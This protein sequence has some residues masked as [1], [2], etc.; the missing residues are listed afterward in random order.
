M[1]THKDR[2]GHSSF[3]LELTRNAEAWRRLWLESKERS[4]VNTR[5]RH[6]R[7]AEIT[8]W[9]RRAGSY[10]RHAE[11]EKSRRRRDRVLAWLA[12][13][14]ALTPE[15]RVLDIGAGPGNYALPLAQRVAELVAL[16]PAEGMCA[17]LQERIRSRGA[18]N[19]RIVQSTWEDADLARSS[20]QGAFDLV[21]ASMSPGVSS[22]ATLEKM[23]AASR[24]HC[25]LSGWSGSSWGGW[26]RAQAELWPLIF[27]EPLGDYPSD[28]LYPFGLLYALGYRPSLRF[29]HPRVQLQM[30]AG[31]AA[32]DLAEQFDRYV[33]ID[34]RI[35]RIIGDYVA[36]RSADGLFRQD[37]RTCQGFML[38]RV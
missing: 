13:E 12:A 33:Q 32:A 35:R 4:P 27:S 7:Q 30:P 37:F 34:T 38:W 8:R 36:Q 18:G 25:Y 31:E 5:E 14:G 22:P 2:S 1:P 19:I 24:G 29:E 9:N 16:E 21:F 11:S 26:G 15:G 23:L 6:G 17:V 20:W 28:V 3:P 10:A